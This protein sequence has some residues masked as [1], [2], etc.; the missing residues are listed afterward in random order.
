MTLFDLVTAEIVAAIVGALLGIA[1]CFWR[2]TNRLTALEE[3]K[4]INTTTLTGNRVLLEKLAA[5]VNRILGFMEATNGP[6]KNT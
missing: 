1:G 5:D 2:V 3:W 4:S 6:S